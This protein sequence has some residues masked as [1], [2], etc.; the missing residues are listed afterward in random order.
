MSLTVQD[1][2]QLD[3]LQGTR[4]LAG[5]GGL[6]REVRW[7]HIWPEVL[8][9][10]HGGELLLTTGHS[11]PGEA[12]D[13]RRIIR[14]L[15]QAHLAAILFATGRF[16][17]RIPKPILT[18]AE[19]VSLPILEAPADI[20]FAE[21]TEII[22]RDIIRRQYEVIE[23]SEEIHK[24]L[25]AS[26]LEARDLSDICQVLARLIHKAV[27]IEDV[28]FRPLAQ[29]TWPRGG[30]PPDAPRGTGST[31]LLEALRQRGTLTAI[32]RAR[33]ALRIRGL[34]SLGVKDR[35]ACPIRIGADL[36]GYLWVL[37][38]TE[39]LTDLDLRAAEHGAVVAA[40]HILR[41]QS[42]ASVE[43]RVRNSFVQALIQGELDKTA[44]LEERARLLGFTPEA[45]HVTG[46]LA[47]LGK[48]GEG[49]K[50][51]LAGPQE[52][53]QRERLADGLRR[54]LEELEL[55]VFVGYLMNHVVFLL[56]VD[57]PAQVLRGKVAD[58]WQR[59]KTSLPDIPSAMALGG[60]HPGAAG[61]AASYAE[62]DSAL[63]ASQG[64]GAFW[65]D[66]LLLLRL[67]R[68]VG[69]GKALAD[70]HARTIGRLRQGGRG[71]ALVDTL[72][73]LVNHAFNQRAAARALKAHWNT[74]RHRMARIEAILERPLTDP[75]LRLQLQL[76]L[77]AERVLPSLSP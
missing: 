68:S 16:F 24:H 12:R 1:I 3:I 44:G 45:K 66:D 49:R 46:L 55:P 77:E 65:Y 75:Q 61:I 19:R 57:A 4:L 7:V 17:P 42:I 11:W 56:P 38:E 34:E 52:F 71:G 64:E 67:L 13:Q 59:L 8:P 69:D 63:L 40:L 10:F 37:Q 43:A 47:L 62:A 76:A 25:T 51:A 32:Q 54:R 72:T 48:D 21:V 50:R 29:A 41:Q 15:D 23:R 70:L 60:V 18:A 6:T 2:L 30:D 36:V 35:V 33:S 58:L 14:D 20:A 31:P 28:E 74:M 22:N 73:A 39:P 27:A 9:W 5:S 53:H 26:A